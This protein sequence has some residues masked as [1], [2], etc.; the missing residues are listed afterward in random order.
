MKKF[1]IESE[2]KL[3]ENMT[4]SEKVR[5]TFAM[6]FVSNV[7]IIFFDN[8]TANFELQEKEV[9]IR[10]Y[11]ILNN[12]EGYTTITTT[13]DLVEASKMA[14]TIGIIYRGKL[15]KYGDKSIVSKEYNVG[16]HIRILKKSGILVKEGVYSNLQLKAE[17]RIR[18]IDGVKAEED[19]EAV[20]KFYVPYHSK[21]EMILKD[22]EKISHFNV[23]VEYDSLAKIYDAI[24]LKKKRNSIE[25]GSSHQEIMIGKEK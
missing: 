6:I 14:S 18:S 19:D 11:N 2:D 5:L 7:K 17:E 20:S 16:A 10:Y 21:L 15:E 22:L 23:E 1:D 8:F 3:I 9:L 13:D 4:S 25:R 24:Q 12:E